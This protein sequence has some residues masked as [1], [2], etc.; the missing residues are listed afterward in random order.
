MIDMSSL[1]CAVCGKIVTSETFD[2]HMAE[3]HPT[4]TRVESPQIHVY[5]VSAL[6]EDVSPR[7]ITPEGLTEEEMMLMIVQNFAVA[8]PDREVTSE[9]NQL[10]L[11]DLVL[12]MCHYV[13]GLQFAHP[14]RSFETL[15]RMY[16][17]DTEY[18]N[19]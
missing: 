9:L 1:R 3:N 4:A 15:L 13:R 11:R 14:E 12:D 16:M 17:R 7:T 2:T 10:M 19:D 6:G 8:A 18:F 5:Y